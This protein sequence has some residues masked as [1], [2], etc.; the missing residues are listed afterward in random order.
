MLMNTENN[1][2]SSGH[3]PKLSLDE[4]V[5]KA[6]DTYTMH[7]PISQVLQ[8]LQIAIERLT[9]SGADVA[10]SLTIANIEILLKK[11]L[12]PSILEFIDW[13][14]KRKI[15]NVL[16]DK[17]GRMFL[18]FCNDYYSRITEVQC[19]VPIDTAPTFRTRIIQ[20]LRPVYPEPQR[21]IFHTSPTLI[22]GCIIDDG[23]Q[24]IDLS[25]Q[26]NARDLIATHI[27]QQFGQ[28]ALRG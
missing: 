8:E 22:C 3:K 18:A 13:V 4:E 6:L 16:F 21:I 9:F 24:K 28:G 14:H 19:F 5:I 1:S 23:A 10:G 7:M 15:M 26:R 27:G 25:L 20:L 12:S 11:D 2:L 17:G